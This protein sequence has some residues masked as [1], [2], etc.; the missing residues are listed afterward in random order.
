MRSLVQEHVRAWSCEDVFVG[1]SGN[2]TIERI[3]HDLKTVDRLHGCDVTLYSCALG[4][5]FAGEMVEVELAPA[6]AEQFGWLGGYLEDPPDRLATILL[7]SAFAGAVGKDNVYWT[8]LRSAYEAQWPHLH[9]KTRAKVEAAELELASFAARDVC[10]WIDDVPLEAGVISYP[11]FYSGGY[12]TM[13][14]KLEQLFRWEAP[15]YEQLGPEGF[16]EALFDKFRRHKHWLYGAPEPIEG[17]ERELV[18]HTQVTNRDRPM[19]LYSGSFTKRRIVRPKQELE[20]PPFDR[21]GSKEELGEELRIVPIRYQQFCSLRSA[22]M[23]VHIPPAVATPFAVLVDDKIVGACAIDLQ[24]GA[25]T[26]DSSKVESPYAILLSDFAVAPTLYPKLSKLVLYAALSTEAQ[27][28]FQRT[29]NS[30]VRSLAT[31]AFTNRSSSMKYRGLFKVVNRN[32]APPE[33]GKRFRVNYAA[34]AGRWS[35]EEGFAQWK[36]RC[37]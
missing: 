36:A 19:Y 24:R 9:V 37:T 28:I 30:R 35:L 18:G 22:Y 11:P 2:L 31:T 21:L 25:V 5:Y 3:V 34:P 32:E 8:R 16:Q 13:F 33:T 27:L 6:A 7:A 1:C 26:F 4:S 14:A 17:H 15:S 12:E 10:E 20:P 23:D 29:A